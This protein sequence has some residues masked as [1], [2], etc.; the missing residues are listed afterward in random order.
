MSALLA[1]YVMAL[2]SC[3]VQDY[4]FPQQ[5]LKCMTCCED[6]KCWVICQ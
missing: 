5:V 1:M 6:G 3:T 4:F 2:Q